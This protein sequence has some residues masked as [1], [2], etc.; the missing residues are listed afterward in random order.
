MARCMMAAMAVASIAALPSFA[1]FDGNPVSSAQVSF[2][3]YVTDGTSY[4]LTNAAEV[5]AW[6]V[7]WKSGEVVTA[8]ATQDGTEY[9]LADAGTVATSAQ[10]PA[11]TGGVWTLHNSVEGSATICIPWHVFGDGGVLGTGDAGFAADTVL[12]GPDRKTKAREAL[13]V[14]F[15]GDDWAGDVSKAATVTFTPPSGSGLEPTTFVR[16][17]DGVT[18]GTGVEVFKFAEKGDWTVALT[19][20]DGS[21]PY[22]AKITIVPSECVVFIR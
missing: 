21:H 16:P 11:L 6:L 9:V 3:A 1:T 2:S 4:A 15:S 20:A 8:T 14:A 5:T 18:T 22:E 17:G 13:P 12:D 19:F 7:T 10:L